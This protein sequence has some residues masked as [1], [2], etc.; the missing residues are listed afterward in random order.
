MK[1]IIS[2]TLV[3]AILICSIN[4]FTGLSVSARE[5]ADKFVLEGEDASSYMLSTDSGATYKELA[6]NGK[7]E[8]TDF[9]EDT[10][11]TRIFSTYNANAVTGVAGEYVT[12]ATFNKYCRVV[13]E[14]D[15][16]IVPAGTY[17]VTAKASTMPSNQG[18]FEIQTY[19]S[20]GELSDSQVI[21]NNAT[22]TSSDVNDT[23]N[24]PVDAESVELY[25]PENATIILFNRRNR[26]SIDSVTFEKID[27]EVRMEAENGTWTVPDG[28]DVPSATTN[29]N[30]SGGKFIVYASTAYSEGLTVTYD[31]S[32]FTPGNVYDLFVRG[33]QANSTNKTITYGFK[34]KDGA[35]IGT[36][37]TIEYPSSKLYTGS[38][39]TYSG[40]C[41]EIQIPS[42]ADK[43]VFEI[44]KMTTTID[45]FG[46]IPQDTYMHDD[47][48]VVDLK[49]DTAYSRVHYRA[50]ANDSSKTYKENIGDWVVSEME[51]NT[52]AVKYMD[53]QYNNSDDSLAII[54]DNKVGE[55]YV[56]DPGVYNVYVIGSANGTTA[57]SL[58]M[59]ESDAGNIN[60]TSF[61]YVNIANYTDTPLV[62]GSSQLIRISG[63]DQIVLKTSANNWN[64]RI[65]SIVFER[66][67][68]LKNSSGYIA[69]LRNGDLVAKVHN[70]RLDSENRDGKAILTVFNT[71]N[72]EL[73]LIKAADMSDGKAEF[74]F[75]MS[76]D[77]SELS[78][79]NLK[80]YYFHDM[81]SIKPLFRAENFSDLT[82]N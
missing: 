28:S 2:S 36:F 35:D 12:I 45:Y 59:W 22:L 65:D 14:G 9:T 39:T 37:S 76:V 24:Y 32:Y 81:N 3:M 43:I 30:Y 48:Y 70:T 66:Q 7:Y 23:L 55:E 52:E 67:Y 53:F 15:K 56:I 40:K 31:S 46:L 75:N 19:R 1:K 27:N 10:N 69:G 80:F 16:Q 63:R 18:Y 25:V 8:T 54:I 50:S 62:N 73:K 72:N 51:I 11:G 47:K 58:R 26:V 77:S 34:D 29:A 61:Q 41:T 21:I 49:P 17:R 68:S 82:K 42:N 4:V 20:D 79:Y 74:D 38:S 44:P 78:K 5:M 33:H 57:K 64:F 13:Y 60:Q 71:E 6:L